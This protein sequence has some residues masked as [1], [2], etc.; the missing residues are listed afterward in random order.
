MAFRRRLILRIAAASH[1]RFSSCDRPPA[2]VVS[3]LTP[4]EGSTGTRLVD[5]KRAPFPSVASR[6][7]IAISNA[8]VPPLIRP[9]PP[10]HQTLLLYMPHL[11]KVGLHQVATGSEKLYQTGRASDLGAGIVQKLFF[12]TPYVHVIPDKC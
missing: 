12:R 6:L 3:C 4:R 10:R 11:P 7:T 2:C 1:S 8:R 5:G 9:Y